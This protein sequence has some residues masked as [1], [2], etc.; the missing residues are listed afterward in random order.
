MA[1]PI[2]KDLYINL[3]SSDADFRIETEQ[4]IIYQGKAVLKPDGGN[5]RIRI[6]DICA[7][8]LEKTRLPE[9]DG[10]ATTPLPTFSTYAPGRRVD[11]QFYPDWSYDR[12]F[13][14]DN[15]LSCPILKRY[16][17][18]QPFLASTM[19]ESLTIIGKDALG[20]TEE[21]YYEND[22]EGI[23]TAWVDLSALFSLTS[24]ASVYVVASDTL[25]YEVA[26]TCARYALCYI[27]AHGG[28]DSLLIE[29]NHS[30]SDSL[31]RQARDVEYDNGSISNRGREIF[32][33]EIS[34]SMTLHTSWLSDDEA[35]RMHHL[36]N[37]TEVYLYD[38]EQEQMIPVI[39][40]NAT[41]EYKTYKGNG[42]KLI[43]YAIEVSFANDRI[44]R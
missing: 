14:A 36:L 5:L 9:R 26:R 21:V 20:A 37:S 35:S 34:K 3:G 16:D 7:D 4:G 27:N 18:R 38:M 10:Y 32:I 13:N 23:I 17:I 2:W 40:K 42:N 29:G 1:A 11:A 44:R 41:T 28:W 22:S 30:E 33:N 25:T 31:T 43:N 15:G 12:S 19:A 6:N 8:Y 24:I 39:L